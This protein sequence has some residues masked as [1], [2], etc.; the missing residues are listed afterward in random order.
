M[1]AVRTIALAAALTLGFA[2]S[3]LAR[4]PVFTATLDTPSAQAR[5]IAQN[6]IWNCEG[7]T[8]VARASHAVSVRACRQLVR[9]TGG[10]VTAYGTDERQLSADEIAR[11]NGET[12]TQQASN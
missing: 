11:C 9:E 3:A 4:D 2:G 6:A 7:E 12:V 1:N 8:C 10:R 5:V